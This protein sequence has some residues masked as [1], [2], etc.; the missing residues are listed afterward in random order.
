[1]AVDRDIFSQKPTIT[2]WNWGGF[3]FPL[4][5]GIVVK[6]LILIVLQFIPLIGQI[7]GGII[8]NAEIDKLW[9]YPYEIVEEFKSQVNRAGV[10]MSI[11]SIIIFVLTMMVVCTALITLMRRMRGGL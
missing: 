11:I 5:I 4:A 9:D 3:A 10:I 2:G 8:A 1:M 7:I 6:S